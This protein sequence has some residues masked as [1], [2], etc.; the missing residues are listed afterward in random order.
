MGKPDRGS[1]QVQVPDDDDDNRP[2]IRWMQDERWTKRSFSNSEAVRDSI[3][4]PKKLEALMKLFRG[5]ILADHSIMAAV[6]RRRT[7]N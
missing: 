3:R 1:Q 5:K 2:T 6:D 7:A 4:D